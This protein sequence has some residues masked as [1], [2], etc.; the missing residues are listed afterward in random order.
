[1]YLL[2]NQKEPGRPGSNMVIITVFS[3]VYKVHKP[4][5]IL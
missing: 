3:P 1:M 5:L 4:P 2:G